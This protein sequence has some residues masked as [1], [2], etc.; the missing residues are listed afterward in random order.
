MESDDENPNKEVENKDVENKEVENKE[1]AKAQGHDIVVDGK[2]VNYS[3]EELKTAATKAAGADSRFSQA[4]AMKKDA[5]KGMRMLE[6]V[7]DL[8]AGTGDSDSLLREFSGLSGIDFTGGG[9]PAPAAAKDKKA[10]AGDQKITFDSLDKRAQAALSAAEAQQ[11]AGLREK[12][13]GEI[14]IKVDNDDIIVKMLEN[15][16]GDGKNAAQQAL[17]DMVREDV[18][19]RLVN[20]HDAYGPEMLLSSIQKVRN[21]VSTLGLPTKTA[22]TLPNTGAGQLLD[23]T[24]QALAKEPIKRVSTTDS[25]YI[26]NAS[27]RLNQLT[28]QAMRKDG[29]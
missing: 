6:I 1:P 8:K 13:D 25:N 11:I 4:A 17:Y 27:D 2:T 9:E 12:I 21:R 15:M 29:R 16:P 24:P 20:G 22:G 10:D 26:E 5:S 23:V 14:K 7:G 3:I 18:R 28:V 19:D